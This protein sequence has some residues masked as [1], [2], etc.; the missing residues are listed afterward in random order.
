MIGDRRIALILVCGAVSACGGGAGMV[1]TPTPPPPAAPTALPLTASATFPTTTGTLAYTGTVY[2]AASLSGGN[3]T[4]TQ[5]T[6]AASSATVGFSYDAASGTYTVAGPGSS[7]SF[8]A[9]NAT[10][11]TGYAAAF[12]K[13]TGTV[14]DTLMLYGNVP[15]TAPSATPPVQLSY[16]SFGYW[17]HTD[18]AAVQTQDTYFVFGY[19]TA[20]SAVPTTG[21]ATY[22]GTVSATALQYGAAAAMLVPL[23]GTTSLTANFASQTV[24]T[25]INL[26]IL[27]G[28]TYAA[29]TGTGTISANQ[30][31]GTLASTNTQFTGGAFTGGFFGPAAQETGLTFQ[32]TFHNPDPYAGAS[33]NPA[34]IAISGA[35]VAKKQ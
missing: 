4:A 14:T 17:S 24:S 28:A 32:A 12:A 20:A 2:D 30:F 18:T 22:Q 15:A 10:S 23:S 21:T 31:A 11:A 9:A 6:T 25:N 3:A 8:T 33:V 35:A 26:T 13:T 29:F 19:P 34:N 27:N 16:A 5:I 7:A 1:S